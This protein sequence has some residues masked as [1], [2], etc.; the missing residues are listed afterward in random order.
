LYATNNII[1]RPFCSQAIF[2]PFFC[3]AW[4]QMPCPSAEH[5]AVEGRKKET[6][7]RN[8]AERAGI[9]QMGSDLTPIDGATGVGGLLRLG[10]S[11]IWVTPA[12]HKLNG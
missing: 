4:M 12:L 5:F 10:L 6:V 2:D 11:V 9:N 3:S 7:G 1:C 8:R